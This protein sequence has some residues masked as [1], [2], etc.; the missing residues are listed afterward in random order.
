[1]E[2]MNNN[3][4]Q[5]EKRTE[6]VR[7]I[8]SGE[9][10]VR[11]NNA[12]LCKPLGTL[13]GAHT[14]LQKL[15]HVQDDCTTA[16]QRLVGPAE[17]KA[18]F[19]R[20]LRQQVRQRKRAAKKH[21]DAVREAVEVYDSGTLIVDR[22]SL[23]AHPAVGALDRYSQQFQ[24]LEQGYKQ[25][26]TSNILNL[27][28]L[29]EAECQYITE[30]SKREEAKY[31]DQQ[32]LTKLLYQFK[33]VMLWLMRNAI[34]P[35]CLLLCSSFALQLDSETSGQIRMW[36]LQSSDAQRMR[37]VKAA[38]ENIKARFF[39]SP[40]QS[41]EVLEVYKIENQVLLTAFQ[42]FTSSLSQTT[43]DMKIKGLFCNIPADSVEHC[44]VYGMHTAPRDKGGEHRFVDSQGAE[45]KIFNRSM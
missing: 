5:D 23:A 17:A 26:V 16:V 11:I 6:R 15:L 32:A 9:L 2:S 42:R 14:W 19:T 20:Q 38:T 28:A 43:S 41:L 45:I 8:Q 12:K 30:W 13:H 21:W 35:Y 22:L 29:L 44:V 4:T 36:R 27:Y 7:G 25:H 37:C 18:S 10:F 33:Y 1:M 31:R 40:A 24:K 39:T 3:P 34:W